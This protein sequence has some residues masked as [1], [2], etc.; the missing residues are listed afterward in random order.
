MRLNPQFANLSSSSMGAIGPGVNSIEEVL[1][2]P[3]KR[4]SKHLP[5][6]MQSITNSFVVKKAL[7]LQGQ[8]TFQRLACWVLQHNPQPEVPFQVDD[9]NGN[10]KLVLGHP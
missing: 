2:F 5:R 10:N 1:E 8:T 3:V 7:S 9:D 4:M 6:W